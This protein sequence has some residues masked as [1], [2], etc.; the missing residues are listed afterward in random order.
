VIWKGISQ[1]SK[2]EIAL[3]RQRVRVRRG[4]NNMSVVLAGQPSD[5]AWWSELNILEVNAI[6][7][8]GSLLELRSYCILLAS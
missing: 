7:W 1:A 8:S 4:K 5:L 3:A 6:L 2:Y